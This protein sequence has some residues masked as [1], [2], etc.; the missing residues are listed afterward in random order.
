[1]CVTVGIRLGAGSAGSGGESGNYYDY[2]TAQSTSSS[3]PDATGHCYHVSGFHTRSGF[4]GGPSVFWYF[5]LP[6]VRVIIWVFGV[7]CISVLLH[8]VEVCNLSKRGLRSLDLTVSAY[9]FNK[10]TWNQCFNLW[11]YLALLS[12]D[13]YRNL[14]VI[15]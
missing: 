15:Y 2:R 7:K 13:D 14:N 1:V 3:M 10:I 6:N 4:F 11:I 9:I 5:F 8:G 12:R